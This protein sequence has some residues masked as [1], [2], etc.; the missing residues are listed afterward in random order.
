MRSH[1]IRYLC[2]SI[3]WYN[4]HHNHLNVYNSIKCH[5]L[6]NLFVQS[7][8]VQLTLSEN[9]VELCKYVAIIH[10]W[11]ASSMQMAIWH[12]F[13]FKLVTVS[14]WIDYIT[15]QM[16]LD[17]CLICKGLKKSR[18]KCS[19][20]FYVITVLATPFDC[21]LYCLGANGPFYWLDHSHVFFFFIKL[22]N[23]TWSKWFISIRTRY[24][25]HVAKIIPIISRLCCLIQIIHSTLIELVVVIVVL[26]KH[27][28]R[29]INNGISP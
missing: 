1:L 27:T 16:S 28:A 17:Y 21:G 8:F 13:A 23:H 15:I 19:K 22:F 24:P 25:W 20:Q 9:S 18:S 29:D 10:K 6:F 2:I 4:V 26:I 14:T 3:Y 5:L 12:F 11:N 7:L